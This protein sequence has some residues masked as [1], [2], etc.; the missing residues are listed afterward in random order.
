MHQAFF[1]ANSSVLVKARQEWSSVVG[2]NADVDRRDFPQRVER[3]VEILRVA[4]NN[5]DE[6]VVV[7]HLT[8]R[9]SAP[10]SGASHCCIYGREDAKSQASRFARTAPPLRSKLSSQ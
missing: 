8:S 4:E 1:G 7:E 2:R 5:R 10:I 6:L 3:L 9:K